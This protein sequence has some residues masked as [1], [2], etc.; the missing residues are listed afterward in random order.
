[1][2]ANHDQPNNN[3]ELLVWAVANLDRWDDEYTHLRSD[4]SPAPIFFTI[5]RW[6][7]R[8]LKADS[9]DE[10]VGNG[11]FRVISY[12]PLEDNNPQVITKQEWMEA[13]DMKT[14]I[15]TPAE[16]TSKTSQETILGHVHAKAM[17]EYG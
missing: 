6:G 4:N 9:D 15:T 7:W 11:Y 1:M 16:T 2:E 12:A 17:V 10:W 3:S 14:T 8:R 5:G 13:K